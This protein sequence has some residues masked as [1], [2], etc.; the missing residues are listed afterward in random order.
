MRRRLRDTRDSR[1]GGWRRRG[2]PHDR[3]LR[4]GSRRVPEEDQAGSATR[5]EAEAETRARLLSAAERL[6]AERGFKDVTVREICRIARAN[7]AAVNYHFR[8]KL[9]LYRAVLQSA[10]DR[11]RETTDVARKA[12]EGQAP[13]EQLRRYISIFMR[14]LLADRRGTVHR[15]VTREMLDPTPALDAI[16]QKGVRPRMEYL[17]EVIANLIGSDA[18]DPRVVRSVASVWT[19]AAA[20][21]ANPIAERLGESIASTPGDVDAIAQHIADFSIAGIRAIGRSAR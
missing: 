8:D 3:P 15:L 20:Y 11:M 4:I 21:V 18:A 2:L 13:E 16:A 7:V 10:I 17:S 6:F 9:G 12:G 19:Q 5:I 1:S 14:R